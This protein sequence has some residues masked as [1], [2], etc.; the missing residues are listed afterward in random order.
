MDTGLQLDQRLSV[1]NFSLVQNDPD[2]VEMSYNAISQSIVLP[3][4]WPVQFANIEVSVPQIDPSNAIGITHIDGRR[5]VVY[6]FPD[7]QVPVFGQ[8]IPL[9]IANYMIPEADLNLIFL[10]VCFQADPDGN[11][12]GIGA[13]CI[14][15]SGKD[16]SAPFAL[17]TTSAQ[18][19]GKFFYDQFL[20][21]DAQ[22]AVAGRQDWDRGFVLISRL[23][24]DVILSTYIPWY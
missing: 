10:I 21:S 20:A 8:F 16:I 4:S 23:A 3:E 7:V 17:V 11:I 15:I 24:P 9:G 14:D 18:L 5:T 6:L 19:S 22:Q 12:S 13:R 2:A 1:V